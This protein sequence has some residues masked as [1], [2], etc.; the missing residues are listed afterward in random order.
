MHAGLTIAALACSTACGFTPGAAASSGTGTDQVDSGTG[1][2][3]HLPCEL[4]DPSLALCLD[5]NDVA[6][7]GFDSSVGQHDG[8]VRDVQAMV[9]NVVTLQDPAAAFSLDASIVIPDAPSLDL[10]TSDQLSIDVW[11]A[12]TTN[13]PSTFQVLQHGQYAI[14]ML[15]DGRVRCTFGDAFADT[16]AIRTGAMWTHVGCTFDGSNLIAYVN[17]DV[18]ACFAPETWSALAPMSRVIVGLPFIGGI[19][20]LHVLARALSPD[21]MCARAGNTD[22]T[23]DCP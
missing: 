22:C 6:S 7:L 2:A 4:A 14:A 19:D 13:P 1:S 18:S 10:P 5:F 21:E 11:L 23:P 15:G 20:N 9:R 8:Q 17:G 12:P 3:P 16:A